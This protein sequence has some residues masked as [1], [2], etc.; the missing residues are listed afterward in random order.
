[1][2]VRNTGSEPAVIQME[3]MSWSQAQGK[4]VYTLSK[5]ILATPPIF[6]VPAGGWLTGRARRLSAST[7]PATR[8]DLPFVSSG[9]AATTQARLSGFT[10]G[11]T[12][13]RAGVCSCG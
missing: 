11:V 8:A 3:V 7:R 9:S 12:H 1:M 6:T 10:G 5:E 4:D 2:T 13:R